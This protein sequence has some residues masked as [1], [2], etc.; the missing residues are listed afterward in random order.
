MSDDLLTW[1][2]EQIDA[3][4]KQTRTL[5][6]WAQQTSLTLQDPKL[7]G[8]YIPGWHAW[9]DVEQL[10]RQHL[11]D[12]N[13]KRRLVKWCEDRARDLEDFPADPDYREAATQ[14]V[15]FL[16]MLALP[17]VNQPGYREEWQP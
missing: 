2:A 6:Y 1:L 10:C 15:W 17:Y 14:A 3:A 13:A 11:A 9:P 12:L 5:L 4:E 16:K 8:K 7:L